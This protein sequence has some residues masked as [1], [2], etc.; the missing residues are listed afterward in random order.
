MVIHSLTLLVSVFVFV[1][2]VPAS[3]CVVLVAPPPPRERSD[4]TP[5]PLERLRNPLPVVS[6]MMR[7][8]MVQ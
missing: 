7:Y 4:G 3:R 2:A 8:G 5:S 1:V 6:G